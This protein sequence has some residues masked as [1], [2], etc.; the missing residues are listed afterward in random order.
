MTFAGLSD[1]QDRAD[2]MVFMNQNGGR[3]QIP[4]PP[5]PR[6]VGAGTGRLLGLLGLRFGGRVA[7]VLAALLGLGALLVVGN[8]VRLDIQ[9]RR[10]EIGVLQLLGASDGFIRRPFVYL[11]AWYG[12]AAGALALGILTLAWM[13]LQA[14]HPPIGVAGLSKNSDT[15]KMAGEHGFLPMSLNLNPGY[16][17][18]HWDSY[19]RGARRAGREVSR[20]N[21]RMVREIF[22]ADTDEEAMRLSVGSSMGRISLPPLAMTE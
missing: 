13:A 22:V 19:E 16:V 11:G 2:V 15:L 1:P 7:L 20:S 14:P 9:S 4:P 12:L 17:R 10:E 8:T 3:L 5:A 18:S 6:G 21:W